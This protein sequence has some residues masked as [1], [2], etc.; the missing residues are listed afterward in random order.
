[1]KI[2]FVSAPGKGETDRLLTQAAQALEARGLALS[3]IVKDM[4][5]DSRFENG[6]DM[7]VRV[8]SDHSIIQIT[9]DLGSGS[10]ACRLNPSAIA[11]AVAR[12]EASDMA[13]ADFFLLNKFGPEEAEGRGFVSAISKALELD[14]PV[15]VGV[16]PANRAAF[17]SFAGGL[18][19][20]LPNDANEIHIWCMNAQNEIYKLSAE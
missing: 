3:G 7:K 6:C 17:D 14:I 5:H 12:V 20:E 13:K 2:A 4:S 16:S 19:V 9:Q 11:E 1:M 10:N 8:L 18:A 15:L